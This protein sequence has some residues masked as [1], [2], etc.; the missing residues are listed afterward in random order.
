MS[1]GLVICSVCGREVHQWG[2][3]REMNGWEHCGAS[4]PTTPMCEKASAVYSWR[5][6][7]VVGEA[8]EADGALLPEGA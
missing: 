4:G 7:D 1:T 5:R 3:K 2:D 6:A 8:C